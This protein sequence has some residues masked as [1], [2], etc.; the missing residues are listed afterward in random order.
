MKIFFRIAA[1]FLAFGLVTAFSAC[2]NASGGG[3]SPASTPV[4]TVTYIVSF[5][6]NNGS[7]NPAKATQIFTAGVPQKLTTIAELGFKKANHVFTGWA[8]SSAASQAAYTDGTLYTTSISITLYAVWAPGYTVTF[9]SKGGSEVT[10]QM[11]ISGQTVSKPADPI[12]EYFNFVEWCSDQA[13]QTPFDFATPITGNIKLYA[14]WSNLPA[15]VVTFDLNGGKYGSHDTYSQNVETGSKVTRPANAPKKDDNVSEGVTTKYTFVNWF[16]DSICETLFD[17]DSTTINSPVTI[18]TKWAE[19]KYYTVTIA[20]DIRCGTVSSNITEPITAGTLVTLTASPNAGCEFGS[21]IVTDADSNP[22]N[23]TD[24]KFTMPASPV[25]VTAVFTPIPLTIE[26]IEAGTVVTF[27][28]TAGTVTCQVNGGNPRSIGSS[29][30]GTSIYL[31]SAGDKVCFYGD[32]A[33]YAYPDG[34]NCSNISCDKDCY[35]YGN[36]MSLVDS[37]NY[38]TAKT[39]SKEHAFNSV[40]ANNSHIKNKPG[41]ELILPATTLTPHCYDHMF[42]GCTNLTSAPA[43]PATTLA[44]NCY[45]SMFYECKNLT[46]APALPATTL[47]KACYNN[48]FYCCTNLTSAPALPATTLAKACYNNMFYC[49]TNLTSAPALPA[50]TLAEG[51]YQGMFYECTSLTNAPALPA[52]K[53]ED[54]CYRGMFGYCTS[55]ANAPALPATMLAMYCYL[56]MFEACKKLASAPAL[57]ATSLAECCYQDMFCGCTSLETAPTLP[58]TT[59]AYGCYYEMFMYCA[60]LTNVTCLATDISAQGCTG[61]WFKGA[62]STGTFTKAP[63]MTSWSSGASGIPEGWTVVDYQE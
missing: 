38:D 62:K 12:K 4:P 36:I 26:A 46:N 22:V 30:Q 28:N 57:P 14:K 21:Y 58:A 43:L 27:K 53:L 13:C 52:T 23:V 18:Y 3:D 56:N 31:S 40:F 35:I 34:S 5:N 24:G 63:N 55:L 2:S 48:M 61:N 15:Y 39:L 41:A 44:E 11:V 20:S 29:S 42:Y 49:C 17:F 47:A 37:S 32:N 60:N 50:T 6:A 51:C 1:L 59:L 9:D 8:L 16:A 7:Q 54:N 45:D 19:T 10:S 33:G 25:T